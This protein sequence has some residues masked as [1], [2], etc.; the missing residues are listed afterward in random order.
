MIFAMI[1]AMNRMKFSSDCPQQKILG[2]VTD[3]MGAVT[4]AIALLEFEGGCFT[5]MDREDVSFNLYTGGAFHF[6]RIFWWR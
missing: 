6:E 2:C 4:L 1:G 5:D 3:T